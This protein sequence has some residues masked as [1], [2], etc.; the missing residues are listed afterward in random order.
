[1]LFRSLRQEHLIRKTCVQVLMNHR[2]GPKEKI[3]A[4]KLLKEMIM[5]A[6]LSS[7]RTREQSVTKTVKQDNKRQLREI[8]NQAS[9]RQEASLHKDAAA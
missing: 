7:K 4:A 6:E 2:A 8:L 5:R 1:M 9:T 3:K